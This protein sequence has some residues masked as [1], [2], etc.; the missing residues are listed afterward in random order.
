LRQTLFLSVLL[1]F[2]SSTAAAQTWPRWRGAHFDGTTTSNRNLFDAPFDLRVRWRRAL[3]AGYSGVVVADGHAVTL[4]SDGTTDFLVSLNSS[5]GNEEWRVPLGAAFPGRDGSAGGPVSTPAIDA[6]T[7]YALGPRGDFVAVGLKNGKTHWTVQIVDALGAAV[8]H[9]G[10]TTSPLVTRDAVVVLTGGSPDR[11]ITAL[12]RRTGAVAWRRGGDGASYQSP[13]LATIDGTERLIVGGDQFLFALDPRDGREVWR[14]EHGGRGFYGQI[15]NP[16]SVAPNQLLLTYRPDESVLLRT[17]SHPEVLWTTRELKLNYGTPVVFDGKVFGYSG[18]FLTCVDAR[19][20]ALL[21]RSRPPG[22]G[23]PIIVDGHLVVLT[24]NGS[25]VIA[26]ANGEGFTPKASL[27]VFSRLVWTPP[28]FAEGRIFARDSYSEIVAIDVVPASTT[29]AA[30]AEA[31][32]VLPQSQFA[33][34]VGDVERA[35]DAAARVRAFFDEHKQMPV[36][37]GERYVHFVYEGAVSDVVLRGDMLEFGASLPM[38]RLGTTDLHYASFEFPP[39]ARMAYQFVR[40]LAETI[41][42]PRNPAPGASLSYTGPTSMLFMPKADRSPAEPRSPTLRGRVVELEIETPIVRAE[43]L[44][45]GGK[46]KVHVYLPPGYEAS[47]DRFPTVY[48]MYGEEMRGDGHLDALLDSQF[49]ATVQP[50]ILVFVE[51]TNAYEYARTFRE[52]HRRMLVDIVVAKIDR[53]FRTRESASDRYLVGAD[54]AGFAVI[55]TGLLF[56]HVFGN[57]ISQSVFPLSKGDQE[58]LALIDRT[59]PSRQRFH[60]DWGRYDP[61]R[62]SDLL[63]VPGFTKQVRDRLAAR[64][65]PTSGREWPDGSAV[66]LWSAHAVVALQ[67]LLP[68]E[69]K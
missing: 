28:S 66:P 22:D 10:F 29:T 45:W 36:V 24:K 17:A 34:W 8:P 42:D 20:G 67:T 21:W 7:V 35:P 16:V 15:I 51:S 44:R 27:D 13:M 11:A 68:M 26:P 55:E 19:T 64:G 33:R 46:R 50:A 41:A 65:F 40:N 18:A 39:D 4:F 69:N 30:P 43:H 61:R 1:A 12:D 63:D 53:E 52:A 59:P 3:G 5:T 14:Y 60:L 56:P 47:S 62:K 32:G 49:G 31:D 6:G 25:I 57:V 23:F 38:K 48:V 54:E 58:L 37:E 9:W 2:A